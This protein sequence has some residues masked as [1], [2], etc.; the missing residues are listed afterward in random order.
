MKRPPGLVYSL[1]ETGEPSV[2]RVTQVNIMEREKDDNIFTTVKN[3]VV[4]NTNYKCSKRLLKTSVWRNQ[5]GFT[6]GK[7][8]L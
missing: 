2:C 6:H 7:K 5:F 1:S 4:V 3:S 8:K